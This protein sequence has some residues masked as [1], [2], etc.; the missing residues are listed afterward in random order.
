M[1]NSIML[2]SYVSAPG[3]RVGSRRR[4]VGGGDMH[5]LGAIS[6]VRPAGSLL[7]CAET[8]KAVWKSRL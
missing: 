8:T 1:V 5:V 3:D 7:A 2:G 6:C 4:A